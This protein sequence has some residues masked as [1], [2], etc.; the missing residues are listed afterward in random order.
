MMVCSF[1]KKKVSKKEAEEASLLATSLF[2]DG[3]CLECAQDIQNEINMEAES[4]LAEM[5]YEDETC[6]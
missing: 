2:D 5:E 3:F 6:F 1:C 4:D